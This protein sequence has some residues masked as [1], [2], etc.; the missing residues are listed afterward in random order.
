MTHEEKFD[1]Y[2]DDAK[3]MQLIDKY[4]DGLIEHY[5]DFTSE[6]HHSSAVT[7]KPAEF[8]VARSKQRV[9]LSTNSNADESSSETASNSDLGSFKSEI[10]EIDA[11]LIEKNTL[12][13]T[14]EEI[15][16]GNVK[17][18][19]DDVLIQNANLNE[20]IPSTI[21]NIEKIAIQSSNDIQIGNKTYINGPTTVIYL[22]SDKN[23]MVDKDGEDNNGFVGS[24]DFVNKIPTKLDSID[25]DHRKKCS[26]LTTASAVVVTLILLSIGTFL[27]TQSHSGII[28]Q[29]Y[30]SKSDGDR[31]E[32]PQ[33]ST[34]GEDFVNGNVLNMIPRSKWLAQPPNKNLSTLDLPVSRVIIIHTA[35]ETCET[36]AICVYRVRH[37]QTFHIESYG[38]DD[39]GYNFVS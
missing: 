13:S 31:P 8:V 7:T 5:R 4:Y 21:T 11:I 33:H 9:N 32:T 35:T 1:D 6:N 10:F 38:F 12:N 34:A 24:H 27:I 30:T 29:K 14:S 20:Q 17:L 26:I 15:V 16:L 23:K 25:R 36:P 37:I 19:H 2:V 18:K 39:I 28:S 3:R 22:P